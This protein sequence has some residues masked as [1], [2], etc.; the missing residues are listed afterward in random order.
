L[1]NTVRE[2]GVSVNVIHNANYY[3]GFDNNNT[4]KALRLWC[5]E[6]WQNAV[7]S[8]SIE[9]RQNAV[10]SDSIE[11]WQ[12]AV[13]SDSIELWKNAV[14]SDSIEL[15]ECSLFRQLPSFW[16]TLISRSENTTES[17]VHSP[18][19]AKSHPVS[20]GI[21]CLTWN[22]KVLYRSQEPTIAPYPEPQRRTSH[23]H[24]LIYKIHF[25]IILKSVSNISQVVSP[26][27]YA[28]P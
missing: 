3:S 9:L 22:P 15:T 20:Q 19:E 14:C 2:C 28:I 26:L 24:N 25:N 27:Y 4:H 18:W 21:S 1:Q 5:I 6:L 7:C 10:C 12:N 23:L 17:T 16:R 13:C 8:D 11:L